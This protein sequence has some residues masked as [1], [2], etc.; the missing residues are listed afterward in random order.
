M[1]EMQRRRRTFVFAFRLNDRA[2]NKT[3]FSVGDGCLRSC[4]TTTIHAV[5]TPT[6]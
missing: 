4:A 1:C 3:D 6:K 2:N 5:V